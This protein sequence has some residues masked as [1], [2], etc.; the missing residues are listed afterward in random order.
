MR[1]SLILVGFKIGT[2]PFVALV[3]DVHIASRVHIRVESIFISSSVASSFILPMIFLKR[4]TDMNLP[5]LM[6]LAFF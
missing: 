2:N 1:Y 6:R 5:F 4:F 3:S